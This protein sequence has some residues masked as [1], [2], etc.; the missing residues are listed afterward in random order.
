[1]SNLNVVFKFKNILFVR[2][3]ISFGLININ[4]KKVNTENRGQNTTLLVHLFGP[5]GK[6]TLEYKDFEKYAIIY[7][8]IQLSFI[9]V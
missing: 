9:F 2:Y 8:W 1:M 3:I 6:K 7:C 5:K 4:F